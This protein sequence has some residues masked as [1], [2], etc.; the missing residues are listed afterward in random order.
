MRG[1]DWLDATFATVMVVVALVSCGRLV[2]RRAW[3]RPTHVDVDIAHVL[4]GVAMAGMLTATLDPVPDGAWEVVFAALAAW[5]V[6]R[7]VAFVADRGIEGRDADHVHHLSHYVTHLVMAGAML[8]M[9][10]VAVP[11]VGP[12]SGAGMAM[13]GATGVAADLVALPLVFVTV[14][15]ASAVWEVDGIQRFAEPIRIAEPIGLAEGPDRKGR[16]GSTLVGGDVR[17]V[18]TVRAAPELDA[19][20][21]DRWLAPRLEGGCHVAMCITMG[22]M[23]VMLL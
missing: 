16:P 6:V 1:P 23:L 9:Y 7:C 15:F 20:P 11:G 10:A 2:A 22:Y 19:G 12:S 8:Y 4:M 13:N 3:S 5:F 17:A 21:A 18:T 14:L